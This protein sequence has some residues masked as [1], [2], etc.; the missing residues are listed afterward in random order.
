MDTSVK[1][2]HLFQNGYARCQMCGVRK[3][4]VKPEQ[5]VET[6]AAFRSKFNCVDA[7][8]KVVNCKVA[9]G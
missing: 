3:G 5:I 7:K 1:E 6:E 2:L 4:K 9:Y 8:L